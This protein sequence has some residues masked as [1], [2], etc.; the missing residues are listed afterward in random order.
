MPLNSFMNK[1]MIFN[2]HGY[3]IGDIISI[4]L[5]DIL[6]AVYKLTGDTFITQIIRYRN[7]KGHSQFSLI[8]HLPSRDILGDNF[9]IISCK[10]Y[11]LAINGECTISGVLK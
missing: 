11:L 5:T 3:L 2:K 1:I 9:N 7:I 10:N 8:G 4:F 6:N